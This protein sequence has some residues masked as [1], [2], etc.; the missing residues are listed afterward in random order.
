MNSIED[1]LVLFP[2]LPE[3][4]RYI[5]GWMLG[6]PS[7]AENFNNERQMVAAIRAPYL[8]TTFLWRMRGDLDDRDWRRRQLHAAA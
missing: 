4:V 1:E 5:T 6:F 8:L 3:S 7:L 2:I